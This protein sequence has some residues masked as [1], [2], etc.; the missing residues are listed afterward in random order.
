MW[1][2][3][4]EPKYHDLA[5]GVLKLMETPEREGDVGRVQ[6]FLNKF[7]SIKLLHVGQAHTGPKNG[8]IVKIFVPSLS[9]FYF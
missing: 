4:K 3:E 8:I 6:C 9:L 5:L 1:L 7:Y 2:T